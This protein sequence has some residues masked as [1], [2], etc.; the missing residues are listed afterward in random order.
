VRVGIAPIGL[1]ASLSGT[2]PTWLGKQP[3]AWRVSKAADGIR[4]AIR[5]RSLFWKGM[6]V[7]F[8]ECEATFALQVLDYTFIRRCLWFLER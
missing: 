2:I 3:T 1:G 4:V 5:R 7:R 6:S 8:R